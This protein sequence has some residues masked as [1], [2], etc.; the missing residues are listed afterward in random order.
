L[1]RRIFYVTLLGS[2]STFAQEFNLQTALRKV[3][4][5]YNNIKTLQL[6]FVQTISYTMQPTAKRTESGVLSLRKPGK[7]RWDYREPWKKIFLSDGKEVYFYTAASNRVEKSKLKETEDM[8]APLAFLIGRLDFQR[9]FKEYRY[10]DEAGARWVTAL[11]KSDKAP[12]K[13]VHFFLEP[14]AQITRLRVYGHDQ[15]IIEF[16]F[17]NEKLNPPLNDSLFVFQVPAGAELVEVTAN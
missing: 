15:S 8:R 13:E 12:Y 17:R 1:I 14:N 11:P 5:R 6:D 16:Q 3:E 2:L 10:R 4:D 7:M 9:D